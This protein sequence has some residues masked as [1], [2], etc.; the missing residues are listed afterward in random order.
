LEVCRGRLNALD[1]RGNA[2]AA[3]DAQGAQAALE[4]ATLEFV[5]D[6]ADDHGA[7]GAQRVAHRDGAAVDVGDLVRDA[8]VLHEAHGNGRERLVDL[9]Q[10]DV[11]DL[12]AG[13]GQRLAGGRCRAG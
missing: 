5:E 7:G 3:A 13:D 8:H 1:D 6:D 2:H 12:Q 11:G 9:E 10:V 4:V